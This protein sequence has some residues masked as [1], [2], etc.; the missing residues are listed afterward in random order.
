MIS[1]THPSPL[2]HSQS[3]AI[4]DHLP[5]CFDNIAKLDYAEDE[6]GALTKLATQMTSKEGEVMPFAPAEF[7]PPCLCDG[8]VEVWLQTVVDSM[9]KGEGVT[10]GGN[11]SCGMVVDGDWMRKGEDVTDS[12]GGGMAVDMAIDDMTNNPITLPTYPLHPSP[13]VCRPHRTHPAAT[14]LPLTPHPPQPSPTSSRSAR[15][16]LTRR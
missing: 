10:E 5:K 11:G 14:P 6:K 1:Y 2:P 12:G 9:R 7:A 3:Q 13:L 16:P 4:Q 8:P 15:C